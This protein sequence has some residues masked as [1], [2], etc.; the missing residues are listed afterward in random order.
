[1]TS[2]EMGIDYF[3]I[4][5]DIKDD[6]KVFALKHHFATVDSPDFEYD[7]AKAWAA[8]G[9]FID[10]LA[11]IYHE[12]F[13]IK[14]TAQKQ[15]R[16]SQQLGMSIEEFNHFVETCVVVG[17]FDG[18][19]FEEHQVLTSRGI[20]KRY[21]H[22]VK[23]RKGSIPAELNQYIIGD[24]ETAG[25]ED[26]NDDANTMS[27]SCE[28]DANNGMHDVG[29]IEKDRKEKNSKSNKRKEEER[30]GATDPASN[31][32]KSAC[33]SSQI[34]SVDS[35]ISNLS[36]QF[37]KP[38]ECRQHLQ[39][40]PLACFS[41]YSDHKFKDL[42]D[43]PHDTPFDAL[44]ASYRQK[45]G[46]AEMT[47]FLQAVSKKCPCNCRESPEQVSECFAVMMKGLSKFDRRKG[48]SPTPLVLKVLED[49][50][51]SDG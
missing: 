8:Y 4:A 9:R 13:A 41:V 24:G 30:K 6:D 31:V 37:S 42:M 28:H 20:Q 16:L 49:R 26:S 23:R 38:M 39:P 15:L 34:P 51:V 21:F 33:D 5:T 50:Q 35:L 45:T 7:H 18:A 47:D 44:C 46:S 25:Q 14:L 32:E 12:G 11:A 40:Y 17:L 1:M 29:Y 19:I 27:T 3:S 22:A 36:N 43:Q 48:R 10:L 2:Q